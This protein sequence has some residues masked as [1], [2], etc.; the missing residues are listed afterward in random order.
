MTSEQAFREAIV[1]H[2]KHVIAEAERRRELTGGHILYTNAHLRIAI[3]A[4]L[5]YVADELDEAS[6]I[7]DQSCETY[8]ATYLHGIA[9]AYRRNHE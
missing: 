8:A 9:D 2:A 6:E 5:D 7:A 4:V 3:G 1:A